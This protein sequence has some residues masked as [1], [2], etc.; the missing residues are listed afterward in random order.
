MAQN[1]LP[2]DGSNT[3]GLGPLQRLQ[4]VPPWW[5]TVAIAVLLV[6]SIIGYFRGGSQDPQGAA[7]KLEGDAE[8]ELS[9]NR[10]QVPAFD[11]VDESGKLVAL[12]NF[13]GKVVLMS[14]WASWCA[15]CVMEMPVFAKLREQYGANGFEVLAINVDST[16]EDANKFIKEF[17]PSKK[18]NFPTYFDPEKK[19][20]TA[21][22]I[23]VLPS[24]YILD[25]KGQIAM[26]G[27]GVSD[28]ES[29]EIISS[30]ESLLAE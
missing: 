16:R 23:E 3:Q 1:H 15:P 18:I 12:A 9:G 14:F 19:G 6:L 4:R 24:N 10:A 29:P 21:M 7:Q 5:I 26:S 25:R 30:L 13:K 8:Y 22:N 17:W 2:A 27:L 11:V 28:W 20:I